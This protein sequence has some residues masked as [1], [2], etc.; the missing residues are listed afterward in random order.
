MSDPRGKRVL[1]M[2]ISAAPAH[3]DQ[4]FEVSISHFH[5]L[6][7]SRGGHKLTA[8]FYSPLLHLRIPFLLSLLLLNAFH[9][10]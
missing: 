2:S 8:P 5:A 10:V 9:P 6:S 7:S 3:R 1:F 4:S